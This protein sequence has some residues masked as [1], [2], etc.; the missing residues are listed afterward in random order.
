VALA[1]FTKKL[2]FVNQIVGSCYD[3]IPGVAIT[4]KEIFSLNIEIY[5]FIVSPLK[6]LLCKLLPKYTLKPYKFFV[7]REKF[8]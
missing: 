4:K 3:W 8:S 1:K 7:N 2:I 5:L 6:L